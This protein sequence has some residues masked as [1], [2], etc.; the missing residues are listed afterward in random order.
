MSMA[1]VI[2]SIEREAFERCVNTSVYS[3]L[4]EH[5]C[6]CG[7]LLGRFNGQAEVKCP[8]CGKMNVIGVENRG[9]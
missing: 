5:R 2:E 9:D 8:K 6:S 4:T 1:R 7:R 3:E